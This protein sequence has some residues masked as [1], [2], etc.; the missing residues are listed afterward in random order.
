MV[1]ELIQSKICVG[2]MKT[3]QKLVLMVFSGILVSQLFTK[4]LNTWKTFQTKKNSSHCV[5]F[6]GAAVKL[7]RDVISP[8]LIGFA[9]KRL[10]NVAD[11]MG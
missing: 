6:G 7:L 11:E 10:A 2:T 3:S 4:I 1:G 8:D 5:Q 9:V